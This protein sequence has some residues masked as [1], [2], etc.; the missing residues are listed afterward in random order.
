MY[1]VHAGVARVA[2][3]ARM[4][5]GVA[6]VYAG[7]YGRATTDGGTVGRG[8]AGSGRGGGSGGSRAIVQLLDP[9]AHL[10]RIDVQLRGEFGRVGGGLLLVVEL[11]EARL[12]GLDLVGG[13][14]LALGA[15]LG[16]NELLDPLAH[17][18]RVDVEL[19]RELGGVVEARLVELLEA[20][21]EVLDLLVGAARAARLA[22]RAAVHRRA[23]V[24]VVVVARRAVIERRRAGELHVAELHGR[25]A[26]LREADDVWVLVCV[27]LVR[28]LLVRMVVV[29]VMRVVRVV[30]G[31]QRRRHGAVLGAV[32][33]GLAVEPLA[34]LV[35]RDAEAAGNVLEL[36]DAVDEEERHGAHLGLEAL[37][38][39]LAELERVGGSRRRRRRSRRGATDR[40]HAE[41]RQAGQVVMVVVMV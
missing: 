23:V 30:A 20:L 4:H 34:H 11:A 16:R 38:V 37:L 35:D 17:L 1:R 7:V 8:G 41:L 39:L 10:A 3:V 5:A 28:M 31:S 36:G 18:A 21:L 12:E 29:R 33:H 9:L 19:H 22:A 27:L 14:A 32:R 15:L 6:R 40:Q 24:V 2:G 26:D 13:A 25:R